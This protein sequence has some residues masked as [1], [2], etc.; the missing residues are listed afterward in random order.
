[1]SLRIEI[2]TAHFHQFKVTVLVKIQKSSQLV[3]TFQ[4]K[5]NL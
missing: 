3:M 2:R 4:S 5:N 1:M